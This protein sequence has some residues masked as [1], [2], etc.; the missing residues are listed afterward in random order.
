MAL[1]GEQ[2]DLSGEKEK[3]KKI[4]LKQYLLFTY[5]KTKLDD[6]IYE[7]EHG[8]VFN[9]G[10]VDNSYDNIYCY[11]K[12]NENTQ[13]FFERKW[14]FGFFA[15]WGNISGKG[16]HLT[17]WFVEEPK[18]PEYIKNLKDVFYDTSKTLYPDYNHIIKDNLKRIPV[19]FLIRCLAHDNKILSLLRRYQDNPSDREM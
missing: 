2:W 14:E 3:G 8:A 16:K 4:I 13:D 1:R 17:E 7:N 11:L 18:S 5:Y 15:T 9:T 10:L 12:P 6:L 19:E